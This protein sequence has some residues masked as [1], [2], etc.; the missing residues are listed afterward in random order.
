MAATDFLWS[1][2]PVPGGEFAYKNTSGSPI[3]VGMTLKADT[4]NVIGA[5][6]PMIGMVPTAAVTDKADGVAVQNVPVGGQGTCQYLGIAVC[7]AAGAISVGATVGPTATSGSI[8]PF[9]ATDPSVGSAL[10]AA[11]TNGD[12]VLVRLALDNNNKA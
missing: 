3:T 2:T 6:Q 7:I 11:T 5:G 4:G 1:R 10:S 9:T 8:G 12:P